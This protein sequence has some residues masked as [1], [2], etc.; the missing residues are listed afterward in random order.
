ML[1]QSLL[2]ETR[3]STLIRTSLCFA[4]LIITS[5]GARADVTPPDTPAGHALQAF[6]RAFNSGDHERIAAYVK[7][8]DPQNSA[9]GL[10]SFSGQ[11]GGLPLYLLCTAPLISSRFLCTGAE[12]TSMPTES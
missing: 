1:P 3:N 11:T 7:E 12:T 9:D 2:A 10:T 4:I 5:L 6:L 8:Y